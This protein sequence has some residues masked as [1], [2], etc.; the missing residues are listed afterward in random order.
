MNDDTINAVRAECNDIELAVI[1]AALAA[2][3]MPLT[4]RLQWIGQIA[5]AMTNGN[6]A[7]GWNGRAG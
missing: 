5:L 2:L 6:R 3:T 1:D 7:L 4:P